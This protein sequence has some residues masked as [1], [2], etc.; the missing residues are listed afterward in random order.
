MMAQTHT[1]YTNEFR[2]FDS[3]TIQNNILAKTP[4]PFLVNNHSPINLFQDTSL[5]AHRTSRKKIFKNIGIFTLSSAPMGF[6]L[7]DTNTHLVPMMGTVYGYSCLAQ[8]YLCK[9][10]DK[11]HIPLRAKYALY[12][13]GAG[14]L[15]EYFVTIDNKKFP[16]EV[17][18]RIQFHPDRNKDLLMG[19]GFY[20]PLAVSGAWIANKYN[21]SHTEI[22]IMTALNGILIEQGGR[23]FLSFNLLGWIYT[24]VPYGSFQALP[25]LLTK[26]ELNNKERKKIKTGKKVLVM[27]G[28]QAVAYLSGII[29][30][31][32]IGSS[33]K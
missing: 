15:T 8:K 29:L 2:D 14:M 5:N 18:D 19:L 16:I 31:V 23:A 1:F 4:N 12:E 25:A 28:T 26:N 20:A 24:A 3:I 30:A 7:L 32:T 13:Y 10:S 9:A 33:F 6:S 17:R 22:F 27:L 21:F 11:I